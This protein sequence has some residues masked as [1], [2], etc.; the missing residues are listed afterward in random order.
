[1]QTMDMALADLVRRHLVSHE[2][3]IARAIHPDELRKLIH[4]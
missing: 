4:A 1:M 2:D 3:A